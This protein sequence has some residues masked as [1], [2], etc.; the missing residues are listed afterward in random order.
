MNPFTAQPEELREL[1]DGEILELVYQI[2]T[3]QNLEDGL[4]ID[5]IRRVL[6]DSTTE[7]N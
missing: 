6:E 4:A 7:D 5:A 3:D 2:A 1:T